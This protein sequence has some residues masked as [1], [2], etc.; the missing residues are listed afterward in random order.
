MTTPVASAAHFDAE[1]DRL[2]LATRKGIGMPAA[3]LLLWLAATALVRF[4]PQ[5]T[6]ILFTFVLT[7]LVFP[8][9]VG[10]TRLAGG[11]LFAKSA[12]LKP[13]GL[14]LAAMQLF[15]WPVVIVVFRVAPAWT[16][17][18]MAVLF[19][20]HFLP[21]AWY[22]RSAGYGVLAVSVAAVLSVTALIARDSVY[23][24]TPVL[25]A[26]CYAMALLMLWREVSALRSRDLS[27]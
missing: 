23:L 13:L 12:C 16:L 11:D 22:Y 4:W 27:A 7:G 26:A 6:A 8:I 18:T 20:S 17:F 3:G 5:R 25:T 15:Y 10:L 21:Y 19:G 1:R 9:G 14:L 2:A 24:L